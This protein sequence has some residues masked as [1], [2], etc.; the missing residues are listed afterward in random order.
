[1]R[2]M[3]RIALC[4]LVVVVAATGCQTSSYRSVRTYEYGNEGR[5]QRMQHPGRDYHMESPGKMEAPGTMESPGTMTN[6]PD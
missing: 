5:P 4:C 2:S 6:D 1:M 3:I